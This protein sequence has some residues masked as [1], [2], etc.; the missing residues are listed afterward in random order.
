MNNND[1][2]NAVTDADSLEKSLERIKTELEILSG[3]LKGFS[4]SVETAMNESAGHVGSLGGSI[5]GVWDAASEVTSVVASLATINSAVKELSLAH[6]GLAWAKGKVKIAQKL[7]NKAWLKSPIGVLTVALGGVVAVLTVL[8]GLFRRATAEQQNLRNETDLLQK[9]T[10]NL[11][12]SIEGNRTAYANSTRRLEVQAGAAQRLAGRVFELA[13]NENKSTEEKRKM[14]LMVDKLNRTMPGL[15]LVYDKHKG[16]LNKTIEQVHNLIDAKREEA[17][18]QAAAAKSLQ[19]AKDMLD[20]EI[21]LRKVQEQRVEWEEANAEGQINRRRDY[22]RAIAELDAM[23]RELMDTYAE[24]GEKFDI[25]MESIVESEERRAAASEAAANS[26]IEGYEKQA[27]A[28]N[29]LTEAEAAALK[30]RERRLEKYTKAATNMFSSISRESEVTAQDMI[31]N[32]KN[33]QAALEE[34]SKGIETLAKRGIDSGLLETLR[35]A[36]PESVGIINNLVGSNQ[37]ELD[38]LSEIFANGGQV[39]T[40]A[41]MRE[42]GLPTVTDSGAEMVDE[43]AEGLENNPNL[44]DAT[45]RM[46]QNAQNAARS[47]INNGD[48]NRAGE[49][50]PAGLARGVQSGT[51]QL[52]DSVREMARQAVIIAQQ[53]LRINSPSKVFR[54]EVG[55]PVAEGF[56][57]GI[58]Q[59]TEEVSEKMRSMI[60]AVKYMANHPPIFSRGVPMHYDLAARSSGNTYQT[61]NQN[62]N[63]TVNMTQ[64]EMSYGQQVRHL[65]QMSRRL[66]K[67]GV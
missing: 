61:N 44:E 41:L 57:L 67:L 66:M 47:K 54:D 7:L 13:E 2:R 59:G 45:V 53:E 30:E 42:M 19:I 28:I 15:N 21:Q 33:N 16:I 46:I 51:H 12:S 38:K 9:Q 43:I 27:D 50:I 34:W 55:L 40:E 37:D 11:T 22:K 49:Q 36:G 35:K 62:Y 25:V 17:K 23:E 8:E 26:I 52:V 5:R 20:A 18:Q 60:E 31:G 39:A 24:L 56:A 48:F 1:L 65:Q 63:Q 64:S 3:E 14:V 58:E 32:L 10:D 6:K 4:G 29:E